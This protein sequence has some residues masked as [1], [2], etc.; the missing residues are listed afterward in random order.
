MK[1]SKHV[2]IL[3]AAV[4]ILAAFAP[5]ALAENVTVGDFLARIAS[6][7]ELSAA[8]GASAE[9]S[10]RSAGYNIP[11]LDL[12]AALTEGMVVQISNSFGVNVRTSNPTGP[13]SLV[14]VNSYMNA[15]GSTFGAKP[16]E[17]PDPV[18]KGDKPKTDPLT[19]GNGKKLGLKKR[20]PSD[21]V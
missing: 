10:L 16:G 17:K 19:K 2:G 14:Q 4:V 18:A 5:A 3:A 15:F 9:R 11:S 20:S 7:K 13:F 12:N 21:P 1:L 6:A 8:D